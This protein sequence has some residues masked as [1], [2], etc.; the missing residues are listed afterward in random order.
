MRIS[1]I[2]VLP[3]EVSNCCLVEVETDDGVIGI[4]LTQSPACMVRPIVEDKHRGLSRLLIGKNP[5]DLR[6]HW[7]TM[8][9]RWQM[10]LG[11]RG[12]EGGLAVNAMGVIDMALWDLAGKIADLPIC[13]LLGGGPVKSSVPAYAS[14]TLASYNTD[15]TLRIDELGNW[16]PKSTES[17]ADECKQLLELGFRN[18]KYG[19]GNNFDLEAQEKLA[20]I[21]E[22]L[23]PDTLLML[24]IGCPAYLDK[25]WDVHKVLHSLEILEEYD[26]FFVEEALCPFNVEG[27]AQLT[28]RSNIKIATGESLTTVAQFKQFID[29]RALDIIQPDAAQMGITQVIDVAR[30]AE[31]AGILTIPHSPWSALTVSS[32]CQILASITTGTMV[33]YPAIPSYPKDKVTQL[34]NFEIVDTPPEF[35][36]GDL[37]VPERPGLGLGQF[38]YDK[39]AEAAEI[40][41]ESI[42]DR[43]DEN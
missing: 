1:K 15:G 13:R 16:I 28:G 18:V 6:S 22:V 10:F 17:L 29:A 36:K 42:K 32:H 24:D 37:K 7:L 33:E 25:D 34:M 4:G 12:D 38:K 20:V 43:I 2:R 39:L 26:I 31:S 23:G 21:R 11:A 30:L 41:A 35:E 27:F 9:E 19:W 14:A 40:F 5:L 3:Y 8:Y